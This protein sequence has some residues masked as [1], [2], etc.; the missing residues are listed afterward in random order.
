MLQGPPPNSCIATVG[1]MKVLKKVDETWLTEDVC[2]KAVC[3][4]DTNG[5]PVIKKQREVC[6][7]ICQPVSIV[8]LFSFHEKPYDE[9]FF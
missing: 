9:F 4:F 3:A 2:E 8:F 1:G 5:R 7:T 6:N